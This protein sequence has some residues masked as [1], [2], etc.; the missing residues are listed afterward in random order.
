MN[1]RERLGCLLVAVAIMIGCAT[2]DDAVRRSVMVPGPSLPSVAGAPVGPNGFRASGE[3]SAWSQ[4]VST[5]S[6]LDEGQPAIWVPRTRYGL[7]VAYGL[8]RFVTIGSSFEFAR[9]LWADPS[10][11]EAARFE[12]VSLPMWQLDFAGRFHVPTGVERFDAS[13]MFELGYTRMPEV[14]RICG[15]SVCDSPSDFEF[16]RHRWRNR[17]RPTVGAEFGGDVLPWLYVYGVAAYQH[18]WQNEGQQS[19]GDLANDLL[20]FDD[21]VNALPYFLGGVGVEGHV[22]VVSISGTLLVPVRSRYPVGLSPTFLVRA[23]F[24]LPGR[25][26]KG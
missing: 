20:I 17:A 12:S 23:G 4:G 22:S 16:Q 10:T 19:A 6:E 1:E 8:G 14:I 15:R 18:T 5:Q 2:P 24:L 25:G 9:V 11:A 26:G 13:L 3:V 7:S 21:S